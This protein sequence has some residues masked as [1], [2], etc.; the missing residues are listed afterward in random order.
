MRTEPPDARS[1]RRGFS[2]VELLVVVGILVILAAI[3]I[4]Y[5]S[6]VRESDHRARCSDNLN[7]IMRALRNYADAN[8]DFYPSVTYDAVHSPNGYVAYTGADSPDPFAKDTRV[9]PNDVTAALWL[10]VR[11]RLVKP[12]VFVCPSTS[13]TADPVLI[14]GAE[15]RVDQRSN[16]F[17]GTHLSYSYSSPYSSAPGYQMNDTRPADFALMADK[18]PGVEPPEL[19]NVMGPAYDAPPFELAKANSNNHGKAGQNV[20]YA[21][22]HVAFQTT[23][24]CGVG[25]AEKRDNIYTALSPIPLA[26]GNRPPPYTNGFYGHHIGPSWTNDSYLVPTDDE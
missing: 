18:N 3:F 25:T 26:P 11:Q 15:S 24:Y 6:K 23:A 22:G 8:H 17:D 9:Q 14:A 19:D 5:V 20:L 10:L 7:A 21:D 13:N 2:F 12:G 4:P 16:F 1:I